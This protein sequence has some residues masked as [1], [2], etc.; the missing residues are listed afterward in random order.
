VVCANQENTARCRLFAKEQIPASFQRKIEALKA[1]RAAKPLPLPCRTVEECRTYC[2]EPAHAAACAS[3]LG[4]RVKHLMKLEQQSTCATSEECEKRCQADPDA[5]PHY[6]ASAD[7]KNMQ[8][9]RELRLKE[10]DT[11][12]AKNSSDLPRYQRSLI[13]KDAAPTSLPVATAAPAN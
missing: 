10:A 12:A 6:K 5:C 8:R 7:Y 11:P 1:E 13:Q 9:Q 4:E 2:S 3:P